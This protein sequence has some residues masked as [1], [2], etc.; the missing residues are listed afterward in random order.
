MEELGTQRFDALLAGTLANDAD[1]AAEFFRHFHPALLR[2]LSARE[3]RHAEDLEADVWLAVAAHL[4]RFEGTEPEFRAWLFTLARNVVSGHRRK[5]LRR[6]TDLAAPADFVDRVGSDDLDEVVLDEIAAA[7]ALEA[8]R[9]HLTE[10]Q[11][12]VIRLRVIAGF[13]A[14]EVAEVLGRPESWV[15]VTQHRALNRLAHRLPGR[16]L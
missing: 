4:D 16:R 2:Y 1:V 8:L 15:R 9:R 14:A 7:E 12:E 3:P 11:A 10:P 13:S 5:G 6:R